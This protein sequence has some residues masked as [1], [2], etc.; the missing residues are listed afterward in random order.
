VFTTLWGIG[1]MIIIYLAALQG[2][3]TQLYEAAEVDGAR[4]WDKIWAIT[5]PM[6]SPAVFFQVVMGLIGAFQQ[7]VFA[8]VLTQGGPNNATLFSVLYLYRVAFEQFRMGF[9]AAIAWLLFF[10]ILGVT[11]VLFRLGG[12]WVYYEGIVE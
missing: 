4:A 8:Q 1:G 7:F 10:V 3:P 12:L 9:A 2:V 6:I 11:A 5:V